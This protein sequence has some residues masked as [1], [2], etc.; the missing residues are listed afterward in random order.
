[1]G[2]P[3]LSGQ[4][5]R[6]AV[7]SLEPVTFEY[8]ASQ[9]TVILRFTAKERGLR[10]HWGG[11]VAE[12]DILNHPYAVLDGFTRERLLH[13]VARLRRFERRQSEDQRW[14]VRVTCGRFLTSGAFVDEPHWMNYTY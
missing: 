1:M 3:S 5:G 2:D 10:M 12:K 9:L 7:A 11:W 6:E 13:V 8:S 14:F 4:H